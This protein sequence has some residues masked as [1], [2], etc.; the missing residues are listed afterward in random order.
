MNL[1]LLSVKAQSP[2][3]WTAREFLGNTPFKKKD[4]VKKKKEREKAVVAGSLAVGILKKTILFALVVRS[5][6]GLD[7]LGGLCYPLRRKTWKD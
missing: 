1:Y 2:K 3:H 5:I 6:F 7:L 4:V